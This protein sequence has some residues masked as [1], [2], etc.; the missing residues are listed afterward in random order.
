VLAAKAYITKALQN[1]YP[2]GAGHG[3]VHHFYRFWR[4][5]AVS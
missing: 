5:R 4:P 3:P 1:S 2:I